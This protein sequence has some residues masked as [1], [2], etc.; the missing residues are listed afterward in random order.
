MTPTNK[1][2][3]DSGNMTS[4]IPSELKLKNEIESFDDLIGKTIVKAKQMKNKATDDKGYLFLGFSDNTQC[5]ITS[6]YN[7]YTGISEDEYPT[8]IDVDMDSI[9]EL[10][11]I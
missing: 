6:Y 10:T 1:K 5:I 2:Q 7:S 3:T 8:N 11:D 4:V 9:N